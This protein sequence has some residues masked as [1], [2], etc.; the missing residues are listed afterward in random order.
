[1]A[2]RL[3]ETRRP[4]T[5]SSSHRLDLP[6][7]RPQ[8]EHL[9]ETIRESRGPFSPIRTAQALRPEY[10]MMD[11]LERHILRYSQDGRWKERYEPALP[12][13]KLQSVQGA[14][15][16]GDGSMESSRCQT[17]GTLVPHLHR[18][19]PPIQED[20]ADERLSRGSITNHISMVPSASHISIPKTTNTSENECAMSPT[21][22]FQMASPIFSSAR[23]PVPRRQPHNVNDYSQRLT[24]SFLNDAHLA[25]GQ[26]GQG[27]NSQVGIHIKPDTVDP[28][29]SQSVVSSKESSDD[30]NGEADYRF[31]RPTTRREIQLVRDALLATRLDFRKITGR[32]A[33]ETPEDESYARQ[34]QIIQQGTWAVWLQPDRAPPLLY[35]LDSWTG[36]FDNWH[37]MKTSP[38]GSN[39]LFADFQHLL[40][41]LDLRSMLA[42][43]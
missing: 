7:S 42:S 12:T 34:H 28:G 37:G 21:N 6:I 30:A 16:S 9:D 43:D 11:L 29:E 38:N 31:E 5:P 25:Q 2:S 19:L 8:A 36:G 41:H 13:P 3:V 40:P 32:E 18:A 17:S 39:A 33:P 14:V 10:S 23:V 20:R 26:L 15:E 4:S 24:V 27:E 35:S 22:F 1:M